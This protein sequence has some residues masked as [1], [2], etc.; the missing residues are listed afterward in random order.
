[1]PV[2]TPNIAPFFPASEIAGL[3]SR[4]DTGRTEFQ[5]YILLRSLQVNVRNCAG[6][7]LP[8]TIVITVLF[9][10]I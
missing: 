5:F 9:L 2:A 7:G 6:T 3:N 8:T 4:W 1:M 10:Q